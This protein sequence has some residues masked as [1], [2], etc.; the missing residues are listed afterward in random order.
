MIEPITEDA[1]LSRPVLHPPTSL[2]EFLQAYDAKA[3]HGFCVGPRYRIHYSVLGEGPPV[4]VVP[5]ICSTRRMFAAVAVELSRYCRVILYN[6]PGT[7]ARDASDLARY[8][9][10]DY[11]R[12]LLVL[13]DHFGDD[14]VPMM[15]FSFGTTI[16]A[17][18]LHANPDRF[19]KAM[20]VGGFARRTLTVRERVSL[21]MLR[22]WPGRLRH[23]PGMN[24]VSRYNHGRELNFRAPELIEFLV[25]E[26]NRTPV[27]TCAYQVL[28]VDETDVRDL[29]PK[30]KQ[31]VMVVHGSEDRLVPVRFGAELARLLPNVQVMLIPHCGHMPH[32]SH[33]ELLAR[34]AQRFFA[35]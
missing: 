2:E 20:L 34:T 15:S 11:W 35:L 3:N 14:Q 4:Y 18:A 8:T 27:R 23:I 30:I 12:D 1:F 21:H 31:P 29:L 7:E 19:P 6:L 24:A 5:G 10:D 17:R 16:A 22:F 13:A 32:L 33:P 9:L 26:S 28:C 25:S